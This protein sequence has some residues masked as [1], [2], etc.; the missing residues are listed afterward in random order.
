MVGCAR[1]S[2][3]PR[4][5]NVAFGSEARLAQTYGERGLRDS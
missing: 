5:D 1:V 2:R 3:V 4:G